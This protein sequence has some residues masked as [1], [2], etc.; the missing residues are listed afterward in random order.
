MIYVGFGMADITPKAGMQ[1]PGGMGKRR[2]EK[3]H[4][5][6]K[7]VALTLL[8]NDL[9]VGMVGIDALLVTEEVVARV[10]EK[11]EP[12]WKGPGTNLLI[13]ASHTHSGG[14]I[15]GGFASEADPA[16]IDLVVD[17]IVEA[18]TGAWNSLHAAEVGWGKGH[19]PS[20]AFNRR[21]LMR[22]GRQV[23]H[24]GKGN[25][26]IVAPAGPIDPDVGVLAARAPGGEVLGVFVNFA[27]HATVMNE[28]AFSADYIGFLR[29]ALRS[30][31][32]NPK[33]PVGFLLGAC[34]DVTQVDNRRPGREFG[35]A[36]ARMFGNALGAEAFQ[37][38][39]RLEWREDAVLDAARV[40]VPIAIRTPRE[41]AEEAPKLGLGSGPDAEAVYAR[42]LELLAKERARRPVI[43]CEVQALRVGDL[44]IVTNG[45][46]FFCRLGLDIKAASPFPSTWVATLTNQ[47]LGYVA[48]ADAF[49]AGGYEVRTARSSKLVPQAGQKL[50]EG[51]LEALGKLD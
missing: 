11:V 28:P 34:G 37:A 31:F 36:W 35:P 48:T 30:Q 9:A 32:G 40:T 42:E 19:E 25:P 45:S 10:R 6:L 18:V 44:G 38:V 24:P 4:D 17:G 13:G 51:A 43:D 41:P 7:A 12:L 47:S 23:T 27:C 49:F 15:G 14:P 46:E 1:S 26:D 39:S 20:I 33:L 8:R 16:Y 50:V 2:L 22:D 5:P 21:F 3:V 29:E